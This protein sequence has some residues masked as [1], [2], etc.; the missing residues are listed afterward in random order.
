MS[1]AT[2]TCKVMLFCKLLLALVPL[3]CL[4][5]AAVHL[6]DA[7][8]AHYPV[9]PLIGTG[10]CVYEIACTAVAVVRLPN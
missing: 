7:A 6:R 2:P 4:G 9:D 1:V 5:P 8:S 10:K 3:V